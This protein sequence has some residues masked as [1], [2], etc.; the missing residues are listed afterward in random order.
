MAAHHDQRPPCAPQFINHSGQPGSGLVT[1]RRR[2]QRQ[3]TA[4][5]AVIHV[6][7][8]ERH[9]TQAHAPSPGCAEHRAQPAINLRLQVGRFAQTLAHL[10]L[11]H[12]V[13]PHPHG[14]RPHAAVLRAHLGE[15]LVRHPAQGGLDIRLVGEVAAKGFLLAEGLLR[16]PR[17]HQRPVV[18]APR[19]L[20]EGGRLVAE[21]EFQHVERGRR[22]L[23]DADQSGGVQP[24]AGLGADA[25]Q[26]LDRERMQER[27]FATGRHFLERGGLGE[28]GGDGADE[29]V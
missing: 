29:L 25:R 16:F 3:F 11:G 21:H 23:R 19:I 24:L 7:Q 28:L 26:P 27:G 12:V 1:L 18:D 10:I 5:P 4:E 6:G 22:E 2:L 14:Q 13:I 20:P 9:E 17:G 8:L 15:Q